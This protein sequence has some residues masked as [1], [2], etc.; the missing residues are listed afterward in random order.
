[1]HIAGSNDRLVKV[2]PLLSII[3]SHWR[4]FLT[5]AL[6]SDEEDDIR[7]YTRTGRPLG[8]RVFVKQLEDT[9]GRRLRPKKPGRK[10]KP[11]KNEYH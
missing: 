5:G 9:L 3:S 6:L 1:L 10:P 8:S 4:E 2:E 11:A 7:G